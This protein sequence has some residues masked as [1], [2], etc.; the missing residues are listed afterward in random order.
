MPILL[1]SKGKETVLVNYR[2]K[3]QSMIL[4]GIFEEIILVLGVGKNKEQIIIKRVE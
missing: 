4:D 2:V 1:V 3:D